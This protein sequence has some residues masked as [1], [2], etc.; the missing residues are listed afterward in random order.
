MATQSP[1]SLLESLL[2][3]LPPLPNLQPPDWAVDEA[4][5]RMV[6]LLNHILMQETEATSR[7]ARQKGRVVLMQW[8]P[9]AL[10]LTATPAGLLDRATAQA[11]P[12][13]VLAVSEESPWA[14]VQG[15]LRGDKPPVRIAGDVQLAAE[16][17]WLVDHVRW[18]IEEDLARLM[19]DAPAHTLGQAARSM[20]ASLR[21]FLGNAVAPGPTKA[22]T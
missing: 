21:Q 13:L 20:A 7:L 6:L 2:Q 17:N 1:F 3:N 19:G 11:K 16:V 15:A 9:F 8:R 14:L 10:K 18:D 5:R 4:Q 22:P 12:D